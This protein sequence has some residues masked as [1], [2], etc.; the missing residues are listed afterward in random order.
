MQQRFSLVSL[1]H[2]CSNDFSRQRQNIIK[3][4]NQGL[5]VC[6]S[7]FYVLCLTPPPLSQSPFYGLALDRNAPIIASS[8][9]TVLSYAS[10][11]KARSTNPTPPEKALWGSVFGSYIESLG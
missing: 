5:S 2:L 6:V 7:V 3:R 9:S 8:F 10:I 4:K 1:G 11:N